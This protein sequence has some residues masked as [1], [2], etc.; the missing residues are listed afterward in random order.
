MRIKFNQQHELEARKIA[1]TSFQLD[2]E[3]AWK[4][5][6]PYLDQALGRLPRRLHDPVV[7]HFLEGRTLKETAIEME[8]P[9]KT[10]EKRI[11]RGLEKLRGY[12]EKCGIT[13]SGT[14]AVALLNT[15][16][17]EAVPP[18]L[19]TSI[20]DA[21]R[22]SP[23]LPDNVI[24]GNATVAGIV[25]ASLIAMWW[26][27]VNVIGVA[28]IAVLFIGLA[29][30]NIFKSG[31]NY[32]QPEPGTQTEMDHLPESHETSKVIEPLENPDKD[33]QLINPNGRI[34]KS[35]VP[36]ANQKNNKWK[37][38]I[39]IQLKKRIRYFSSDPL[40]AHWAFEMLNDVEFVFGPP[41][42]NS[43]PNGWSFGPRSHSFDVFNKVHNL[44]YY[45]L[46]DG[47]I[48]VT[49]KKE[50][51][52]I[53]ASSEWSKWWRKGQSLAAE[54]PTEAL[55]QTKTVKDEW[56]RNV[57]QEAIFSKWATRD[58]LGLLKYAQ[59]DFQPGLI[60]MALDHLAR[61]NPW[62]AADWIGLHLVNVENNDLRKFRMRYV[63]IVA[64]RWAKTNPEQALAWAKKSPKS[65]QGWGYEQL[66]SVFFQ[67]GFNDPEGAVEALAQLD[68]VGDT[69][70]GQSARKVV[71]KVLVAQ[72]F[73][74]DPQVAIERLK[75]LAA[76]DKENWKEE[77]VKA[78][79]V[80]YLAEI[81]PDQA[82]SYAQSLSNVKSK[83]YIF[84][85]II[86][87]YFDSNPQQ[88]IKLLQSLTEED[89]NHLSS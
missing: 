40:F 46:K 61:E 31:Q 26:G 56:E 60:Y 22:S 84:G 25:E 70:V 48:Y 21:M 5:V 52:K 63:C 43:V 15:K 34:S 18:M 35:V 77:D 13:L 85:K 12:L 14:M 64:H 24:S 62:V 57:V 66:C 3:R 67:W 33:N 29:S 38:E 8:A 83:G 47:K 74:G 79:I 30:R 80:N 88:A 76:T 39:K 71:Q 75:N 78:E 89:L 58:P 27:K 11:Q 87:H 41:V 10:I 72:W 54:D 19:F 4:E 28:V 45:L 1:A 42:I 23:T 17:V 16:T 86:L 53:K 69:G 73:N 59:K 55:K 50:I 20:Q 36:E 65:I 82:L 44:D 9:V 2:T 49:T 32:V 37:E 6:R 81:D 68:D 51:S 7:L